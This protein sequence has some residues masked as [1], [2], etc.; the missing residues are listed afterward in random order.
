VS[1][2]CRFADVALSERHPGQT[3]SSNQA[4]PKNVYAPPWNIKRMNA[5]GCRDFFQALTYQQY[6]RGILER[7]RVSTIQRTLL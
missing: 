4:S 5:E 3:F 2:L 1:V 6:D 7:E